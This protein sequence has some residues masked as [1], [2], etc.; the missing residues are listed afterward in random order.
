MLSNDYLRLLV[1]LEYEHSQCLVGLVLAPAT[2]DPPE[3]LPVD[4][5]ISLL[6]VDEGSIL[7]PL[8][9]LPGVDLGHQFTNVCGG[10]G[11][12]FEAGLVDPGLQ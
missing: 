10:R 9:A 1:H 6:Q 3:L 7:P 8:L 4:S 5:V 2:Q 11:A 12:L